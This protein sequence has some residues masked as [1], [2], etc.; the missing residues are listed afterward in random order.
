MLRVI[1][2][3]AGS[4]VLRFI[5][6]SLKRFSDQ[7]DF[8]DD[9]MIRVIPCRHQHYLLEG[10]FKLVCKERIQDQ[11]RVK[12]VTHLCEE[13]GHDQKRG[14]RTQHAD[15]EDGRLEVEREVGDDQQAHGRDVHVH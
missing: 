4:F 12:S 9:A 15:L 6:P 5:A 13:R 3:G 14:E 1:Q 10:S 11:E 8:L 2:L 7:I